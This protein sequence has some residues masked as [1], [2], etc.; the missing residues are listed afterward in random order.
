MK[1]AGKRA[2]AVA[3]AL[4]FWGAVWHLLALRTDLELILPRP[5]AVLKR[6]WELAGTAD[7]YR[8]LGVSFLRIGTGYLAGVSGGAVLALGAWKIKPLRILLEP[9]MT[10]VRAT[11]VASFIIVVIL[12]LP[13]GIVPGFI[14][15]LLVLPVV[16]RNVLLGLDGLDREWD[17]MAR[18]FNVRGWKKFSRVE[19]PQVLPA[20]A[21]AAETGLGLAWKAGVAAEV[22]ALP[23]ASIG[24]MIYDAKLY[25]ETPD[26][27]AWTLAIILVSLILEALF[28]LL[29]RKAGVKH[30]PA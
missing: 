12:W 14:A 7:F 20:L 21:A 5:A 17:E 18:S 25:L 23:K 2:A 16:W 19:I 9:L 4:L 28:S 13:R 30:D 29:F 11:P 26:L 3:V 6:L 15:A 8:T 24:K 22:L 1:K 27:Y 10:V